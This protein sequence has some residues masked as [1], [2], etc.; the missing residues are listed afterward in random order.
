MRARNQIQNGAR[1]YFIRQVD[2]DDN[3]F[4]IEAL[5]DATELPRTPYDTVQWWFAFC[6]E[7]PIAY[8]GLM[9]SRRMANAAYLVRVGV[10][11]AHRGNGLQLRLMRV[12]ERY[13]RRQGFPVI[14]SDTTDNPPSAN[15]FIRAGYQMFDPPAPWAFPATVYW[16]KDLRKP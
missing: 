8:L 12:A 14:I 3:V 16:R 9:P 6:G 10:L 15:N 1:P 5:Q 2:A 4:D 11:K 13:A 7:H